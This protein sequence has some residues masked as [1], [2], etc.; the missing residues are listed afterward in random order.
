[1]WSSYNTKK[2]RTSLSLVDAGNIG[3]SLNYLLPLNLKLFSNWQFCLNYAFIWLIFFFLHW[4]NCD[5]FCIVSN[6]K[7]VTKNGGR[8]FYSWTVTVLGP[9]VYTKFSEIPRM[10]R[11]T[12]SV[13]C[14]Q[15]ILDAVLKAIFWVRWIFSPN[16]G[17]HLC[18]VLNKNKINAKQN[19]KK[20][21]TWLLLREKKNPLWNREQ[22]WRHLW[23]EQSPKRTIAHTSVEIK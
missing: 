3:S 12:A 10:N 16:G 8:R 5:S 6:T 4:M 9:P 22:L 11:N 18:H 7:S 1:M 21:L 15:I 23:A 19:N 14:F 20:S 2:I 13:L 17:K